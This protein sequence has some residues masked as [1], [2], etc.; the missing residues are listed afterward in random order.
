[1]TEGSILNT[2]NTSHA[3]TAQIDMNPAWIS[4]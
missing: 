2:K 4:I 3:V 1:L